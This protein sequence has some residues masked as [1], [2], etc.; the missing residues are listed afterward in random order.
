MLAG[1]YAPDVVP[2]QVRN[3]AAV[4]DHAE[5]LARR[6]GSLLEEGERLLLLGGDCSVLLVTALG[7]RQRGRFGLVHVD[8]H[9]DFRHPGNST[10]G[11]ASRGRISRL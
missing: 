4:L 2:E 5:R 10:A 6:V 9:T 8:G 1:R 11:G 7:L 3:Q